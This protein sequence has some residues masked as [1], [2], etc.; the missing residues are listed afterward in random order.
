MDFRHPRTQFR[1]LIPLL[2]D[3]YRVLAPDLPT[4]GHTTVPPDFECTFANLASV[5][6]EWLD[7]LDIHLFVV[8]VFDWGAPIA[9]RIA[10]ERK[11]I[12]SQ[13]GN[14]YVEGMGQKIGGR[15]AT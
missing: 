13:N 14:A 4:F 15:T 12:I 10:L 8:Y 3:D 11:L 1:K 5:I 9:F 2:A 6:G 7:A